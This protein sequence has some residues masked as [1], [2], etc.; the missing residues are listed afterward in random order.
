MPLACERKQVCGEVIFLH[1]DLIRNAI[2]PI[3]LLWMQY[4]KVGLAALT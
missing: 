3:M 4:I 2:K 1:Y